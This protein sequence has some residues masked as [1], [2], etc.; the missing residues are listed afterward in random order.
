MKHSAKRP[1]PS[2]ITLW[3][4]HTSRVLK[5][6]PMGD[7]H[8]RSFPIILPPSYESAPTRRYPVIY[9]LAGHFGAGPA[10]MNWSPWG[11]TLAQRL[12]RLVARRRMREAIVVLPDCFTSL[13]GAQYMNSTAVGRYA[14]Y[15]LQEIV[16]WVDNSLRSIPRPASRGI[17][18]KSSGAYGALTLAMQHPTIFGL[19]GWRSGDAYFDFCYRKDIPHLLVMLE[20]F[21]GS[22]TKFLADWRRRG[23]PLNNGYADVINILAMAACYAPNPK[24]P[25]GF[26]L[27]VDPQTGVWNDRVWRRWLT[28]DPIHNVSRYRSALQKLKW[29]YLEC[30][31]SDEYGLLYGTRQLRN[32][33]NRMGIRT[34]YEE[35]DGGHR[36]TTDRYDHVLSLMS[37]KFRHV[38][39]SLRTSSPETSLF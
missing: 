39:P 6:N 21:G 32:S 8:V 14:D 9:V 34:H 19:C 15:L 24:S 10:M 23:R 17:I 3:V 18:G 2:S 13:G 36:G 38:S 12:D 25:H 31:R 16:P 27:P 22:V 26:D 29:I 28:H 1:T 35:F 33:L 37:Q 7:P 30:G 20:P 11:E 5:G 4:T